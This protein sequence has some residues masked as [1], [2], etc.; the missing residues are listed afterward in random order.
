[1]FFQNKIEVIPFKEFMS[2]PAPTKKEIIPLTTSV[3]SFL[4][5]FTLKGFFPIHD[6]GFCL[7]LVG[8]AA[9]AG[10]AL[11]EKLFAHGGFIEVSEGVGNFLKIVLP[12]VGYG[13]IIWLFTTL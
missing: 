13:L 6:V 5:T 2:P 1:M 12:V 10:M 8:S 11:S 9:V 7:F 3:F 4:P